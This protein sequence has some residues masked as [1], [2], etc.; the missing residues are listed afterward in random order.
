MNTKQNNK[1]P[2]PQPGQ[3][4]QHYKGGQYE[5]VAM[6]NHTDTNEA[7]VV[8]KSLSFGGY[9]ARPYSEWYDLINYNIFGEYVCRFEQ[10]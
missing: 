10:I 3:K 8:Y 6:C 2:Y 9:H 1:G 4:W 5:I 7:L